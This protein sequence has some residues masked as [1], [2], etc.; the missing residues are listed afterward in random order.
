MKDLMEIGLALIATAT[1]ALVIGNARG[2]AT[3]IQAGTSGF[4]S[5]LKTVTLQNQSMGVNAFQ[6]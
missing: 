5:L 3:V 6:A 1:L 4:N 2:T